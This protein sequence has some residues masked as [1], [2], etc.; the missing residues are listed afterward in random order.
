[1]ILD[2]LLYDSVC[3]VTHL[4]ARSSGEASA[5]VPEGGK[6]ADSDRVIWSDSESDDN[7]ANS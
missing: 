7:E 3:E 5:A 4:Q 6:D 2:A 1:M